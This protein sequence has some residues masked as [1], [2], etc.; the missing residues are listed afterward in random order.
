MRLSVILTE[1][2]PS[3]SHQLVCLHSSRNSF[4]PWKE[5]RLEIHVYLTAVGASVSSRYKLSLEDISFLFPKSVLF[6]SN[7][8]WL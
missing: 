3:V 5:N 8:S 4:V 6:H 1:Q 7:V 2:F